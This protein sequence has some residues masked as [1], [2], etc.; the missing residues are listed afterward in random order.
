MPIKLSK[1]KDGRYYKQVGYLPS[2]SQPKIY[3]GRDEGAALLRAA[4]IVSIWKWWQGICR[5]TDEPQ[6]WEDYLLEVAKAVGEGNPSVAIEIDAPADLAAGILAGVRRAA[7]QIS[8]SLKD[9]EQQKEGEQYWRSVGNE[10]IEQAREFMVQEGNQRL[11]EAIDA[12]I[13]VTKEEYRTPEGVVSDWGQTKVRQITFCKEHLPDARLADLDTE[14]IDSLLGV[15]ARRPISQ[16]TDEPISK[17]TAQATIKEFRQFLR[18]LHKTKTF[19]WK[20][21]DDYE[22]HPIRIRLRPDE[23]SKKGAIHVRTYSDEQLKTLWQYATPWE[24]CLMILGLN[25]GF[26]MGEIATLRRD[27]VFLRQTHPFSSLL[28]LSSTDADS[29]I[30][31]VRTKTD[32][33]GEWKLWPVTVAALEWLLENRPQGKLPYIVVTKKGTPFK[34]EGQR[35]NQIMNAWSRLTRRVKKDK[36]GFTSLSFNKLRK[37]SANR[38]RIAAGDELASLFLSHGQAVG[39]DELLANYTNPRFAALHDAID[40]LGEEMSSV[41]DGVDEP[42]P[43]KEKRGGAN[44]S[45]KTIQRIAELTEAGYSPKVIGEMLNISPE[46][47]RRRVKQQTLNAKPANQG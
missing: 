4:Q 1:K 42:F 5:E 24:R 30:R 46:T 38:I 13:G 37:T 47:V 14:K 6:V 25:C 20:K 40:R 18:W 12:Y 36:E 33:Y 17:V 23:K 26:G 16:K 8:I 19:V 15:I 2:G 9:E 29:W 11:H 39:N 10:L 34:V 41:F 45:V 3:L 44:I 27:E 35:N 31:R 7:P 32:V 43:A 21:P 28:N 22:V